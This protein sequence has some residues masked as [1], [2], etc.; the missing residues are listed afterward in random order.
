MKQRTRYRSHTCGELRATDGGKTVTLCGFFVKGRTEDGFDLRDRHGFTRIALT[1]RSPADLRL[2]VRKLGP[3]DVVMIVGE[4]AMRVEADPTVPTGDVY[5]IPKTLA[6]ISKADP[7]PPD[8]GPA[9][10]G[11][12]DLATRLKYRYLDLRRPVMQR[13]LAYRSKLTLEVR[14]YLASQDF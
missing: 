13:R 11:D 6:V 8:I 7:L 4:V 9:A 3:E 5:V 10:D 12:A 2:K 1:P 14:S